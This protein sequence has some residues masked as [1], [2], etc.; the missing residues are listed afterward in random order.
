MKEIDFLLNEYVPHDALESK[1][2]ALLRRF[3][4]NTRNYYERPN[5]GGGV[6]TASC[7]VVNEEMTKTLVMHHI[8]HDFYKQFGGHADGNPDLAAVA[9]QELKEEASLDGKLLSRKPMDFVVWNCPDRVKEGEVIPAHVIYDV[10]F[11]MQV[12]ERS[13]PRVKADEGFRIKWISLEE[14]RDMPFD[15][16]NAVIKNNPHNRDY[17]RRTHDKIVHLRNQRNLEKQ[18]VSPSAAVPFSPKEE[19]DRQ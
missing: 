18:P 16:N 19:R 4:E 3:V 2:I 12:S 10:A 7:I 15:G 9:L 5:S 17:N 11:L 6:I 8:L 1:H 13:V 14:W